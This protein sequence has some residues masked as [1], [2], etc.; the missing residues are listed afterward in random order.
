MNLWQGTRRIRCAAQLTR[1]SADYGYFMAYLL[2]LASNR[3]FPLAAHH[4]FGRLAA[5]VDT[6]IDRPYVSKLHAAIEWNGSHWQIKH[7]GLNGTWV[8]GVAI[9]QGET[10]PLNQGDIIHI[11]EQSD[12]GFEVRDL[13]P[14]MDMLWPLD[15]SEDQAQPMPL[16]RYHLLPDTHHPELAVYFDEIDQQWY[17]EQIDRDD[18]RIPLANGDLL[19]FNNSQWQFISAQIYG[20]TEARL[21]TTRQLGDYDFVFT[22][23]LDEETTELALHLGSQVIDLGVRTH[24][25]LLLQLARHRV[26]DAERGL[27]SKTRGWVYADTLASELGLDGTHMN[28]QIFRARKQMADSL[29]QVPLQQGLLERRGGKIRFGCDRF[30]IY[31]GEKLTLESPPVS[32]TTPTNA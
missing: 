9:N 13:N 1:T 22:L 24:H 5:S 27:D 31:K 29:P 28:I 21:H 3:L 23:S 7:L 12:P 30:K 25:Y 20:P 26:E 14:P 8:N 10:H 18:P 17:R 16:V 19:E 32:H 2:D 4:T 15:Q 11:A 6:C